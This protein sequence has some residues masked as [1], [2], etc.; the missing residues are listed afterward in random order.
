MKLLVRGKKIRKEKR[1][2][3]ENA[4]KYENHACT[5]FMQQTF[6]SLEITCNK[7]K[8]SISFQRTFKQIQLKL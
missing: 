7:M 5:Y 1:E 4:E 2:K 6:R 8:L 3:N